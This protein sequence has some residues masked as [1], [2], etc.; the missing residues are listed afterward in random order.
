VIPL[1]EPGLSRSSARQR[2]LNLVRQK[3]CGVRPSD[4]ASSAV[5]LPIAATSR[6]DVDPAIVAGPRVDLR[7]L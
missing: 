4:A 6:D 1:I 3:Q 2:N 7:V 5:Q